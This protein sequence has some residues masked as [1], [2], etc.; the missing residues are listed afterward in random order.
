MKKGGGKTKGGN[1][2]REI[3][4]TLT[5]WVTGKR[6]P[7]IFWRSSGSGAQFTQTKGKGSRMAADLVAVDKR[8]SFLTDRFCIEAK[9][10]KAVSFK[11][12]LTGRS[13]IIKWWGQVEADAG[14]VGRIPCLIFKINYYPPY[15]MMRIETFAA[16]ENIVGRYEKYLIQWDYKVI[17]LLHEFLDWC[18][19]SDLELLKREEGKGR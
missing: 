1:W 4:R 8:G 19:P 13:G 15:L 3:C 16:L 18:Q 9:H 14:K 11:G 12:L 10:Y 7:V 6:E 17:C 5:E 2:E